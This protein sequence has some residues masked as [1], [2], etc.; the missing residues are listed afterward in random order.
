MNC[1]F[2][3]CSLAVRRGA[4]CTSALA[5]LSPLMF[6]FIAKPVYHSVTIA[7]HKTLLTRFSLG[8]IFARADMTLCV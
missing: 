6:H 8:I 1:C 3:Q 2:Q 5:L 7:I 4:V